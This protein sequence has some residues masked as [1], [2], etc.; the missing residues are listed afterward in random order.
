M[1]KIFLAIPSVA[2]ILTLV[3]IAGEGVHAPPAAGQI[4]TDGDGWDDVVEIG[5]TTDPLVPCGTLAWPP[6]M[7]DDQKVSGG[8]ATAIFPS[9]LLT[10]IDPGWNP[11]FNLNLDSIISGGDVVLLFPLWLQSCT[12][13][14]SDVDGDGIGDAVDLCP[15]TPEDADGVSSSDGCP[16]VDPAVSGPDAGLPMS[17]YVGF[18]DSRDFA[19]TV[20]NLTAALTPSQS[21][22]ADITVTFAAAGGTAPAIAT[23]QTPVTVSSGTLAPLAS[24]GVIKTVSLNCTAGASGTVD[25]SVSV[26]SLAPADTVEESGSG[27]NNVAIASLDLSCLLNDPQAGAFGNTPVPP[28]QFQPAPF[29][30]P[31]VETGSLTVSQIVTNNSS[32]TPAQT[33]TIQ[34][35]WDVAVSLSG[36]PSTALT[37]TWTGGGASV[38]KT[39]A[40]IAPGGS[41]TLFNSLDLAC[42]GPQ[43]ADT[44][45]DVTV[46]STITGVV[47]GSVDFTKDVNTGNNIAQR[48]FPVTCQQNTDGDNLVDSLDTCVDLAEDE[49]GID[50]GDGCPDADPV[51]SSFVH[52]PFTAHV[53]FPDFR[54]ISATVFNSSTAA[55]PAASADADITVAFAVAS[56]TAPATVTVQLPITA[57]TGLLTPPNS[58][59][60]NKSVTIDC[61]AVGSGTV[62]ISIS[63]S[64]LSPSGTLEESGTAGNNVTIA[65]FD[66]NC[67]LNDP[68]GGAFNNTPAPTLQFQPDPFNVPSL[69]TGTVSVSQPV[70]NGSAGTPVQTAAIQVQWTAAVAVSGSPSTALSATWTG[71]GANITKTSSI[72]APAGSE[73][74]SNDLDLACVGPQTSD[75]IYDVTISS[76]IT[77]VVGG[78]VDFT[79]DA[80]TGNNSAQKTFQVTCQQN[81]DGDSLLDSADPTPDHDIVAS[82]LL[83]IGPGVVFA[84]S[85]EPLTVAFDVTNARSH[86]ETVTVSLSVTNLP[87]G[88]S[89]SGTGTPVI[90]GTSIFT[91]T[92]G[93]LRTVQWFAT[94]T[95]SPSASGFSQ[96]MITASVDHIPQAGDGDESTA[97]EADNT[98]AGTEAVIVA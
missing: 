49:D 87:T 56:N 75:T 12:G 43:A 55:A 31:S 61:T 50:D 20:S 70:T 94:I 92:G 22:S 38:T 82:N 74:L 80:D 4:D 14:G 32:G 81:T 86:T 21:A 84:G 64:N 63:V 78:S 93:E 23:V 17:V 39:S 2:F 88:C 54:N 10:D 98:L 85:S 28:L 7:N 13:F 83:I 25:V 89:I 18:P 35:Q 30:D 42:V 72:L 77:G 26:S 24:A 37:A 3:L 62:L 95:C 60:I 44:T 41:D 46:S 59:V 68:Q 58:T 57:S 52:T 71:G 47:G 36:S 73:I 8:D 19:A 67:L 76:S 9:W 15:N 11:R 40:L 34:A 53:G 5:V 51:V 6:D 65:S 90:P 1:A 48:T 66:V 29:D 79:K 16:D 96:M 45:Y 69:E 27:A 97:Q 91:L 33:A